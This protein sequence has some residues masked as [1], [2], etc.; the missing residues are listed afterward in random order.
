MQTLVFGWYQESFTGVEQESAYMLYAGYLKGRDQAGVAIELRVTSKLDNASKML[1]LW[2]SSNTSC[3]PI[4]SG[5]C[6][7]L[8]SA[9]Y[10]L[11]VF[12][13]HSSICM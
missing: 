4:T 1:N 12:L 2:I 7:W 13:K 8:G 11:I 10:F 6:P 5:T 9:A 3:T